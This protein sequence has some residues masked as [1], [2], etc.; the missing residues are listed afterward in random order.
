M[1][2]PRSLDQLVALAAQLPPADR[3]RLV[4]R[5]VHDLASSSAE[6]EP[7]SRQDWMS[8]RGIAPNLL[9]GEDAQAWVSRNRREADENRQQPL[10]QQP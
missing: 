2:D 7:H 5:I 6:G 9:G 8:L 1:K 3:L 4:E 10:R